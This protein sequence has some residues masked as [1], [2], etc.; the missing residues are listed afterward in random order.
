MYTYI[1]NLATLLYTLQCLWFQRR[2]PFQAY[3]CC[4]AQLHQLQCQHHQLYTHD[5]HTILFYVFVALDTDRD[6]HCSL[7]AKWV[8]RP[9]NYLP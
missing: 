2:L 5:H 4:E 1:Y 3:P 6:D 9:L 7:L 8:E